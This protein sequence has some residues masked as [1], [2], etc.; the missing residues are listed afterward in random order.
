LP[1][2]LIGERYLQFDH[3]TRNFYFKSSKLFVFISTVKM[4][5]SLSILTQDIAFKDRI[6]GQKILL[7]NDLCLSVLISECSLLL[8]Q[9]LW[10]Y[11]QFF[12]LKVIKV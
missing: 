8:D 11:L 2:E 4:K 9:E 10:W 6:T 1:V 7:E 3:V 5:T 12:H